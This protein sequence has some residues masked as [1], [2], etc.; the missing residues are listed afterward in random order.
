MSLGRTLRQIRLERGMTL[1]QLA[2]KTDSH[3]G[4][5]SR[6]ERDAAKPSLELLFRIAKALDSHL[7]DI[8]SL[9]D[10]AHCPDANQLTLN[11]VF[12]SLEATDRELLLDFA[13]LLKQRA[14]RQ[15]SGGH[16][17]DAPHDSEPDLKS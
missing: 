5:L 8:F 13:Q 16:V 7:S 1:A 9:S 15:Q 6:I 4:N 10:E 14:A 12:A 11:A 2:E 17:D 3:V